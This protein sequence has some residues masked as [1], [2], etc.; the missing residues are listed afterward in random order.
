MRK[1]FL[2]NKL[3]IL[4]GSR[5][6]NY[7]YLLI[8][9]STRLWNYNWKSCKTCYSI[10]IG[11]LF[12]MVFGIQ[13]STDP[14]WNTLCWK[15]TKE[16]WV[17]SSEERM[18]QSKAQIIVGHMIQHGTAW[19]GPDPISN[20]SPWRSTLGIEECWQ[21]KPKV[22]AKPS[23]LLKLHTSYTPVLLKYLRNVY[24][25][26]YRRVCLPAGIPAG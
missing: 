11:M 18:M 20:L 23:K 7:N 21:C 8:L 16:Q 15:T 6:W 12:Y 2:F 5:L 22:I 10:S 24:I 3:L 13:L 25:Q 17:L 26:N 1:E 4:Y 14:T 9:Y 19:S